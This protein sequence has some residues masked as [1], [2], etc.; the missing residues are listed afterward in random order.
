MSG[1]FQLTLVGCRPTGC[2][3]IARCTVEA[4]ETVTFAVADGTGY[5]IGSPSNATATILNDDV[6]SASIAVSSA[7][8]TADGATKLIYTVTL[9]QTPV[10]PVSVAFTV[11]GTATSGSHYAAVSLPLVIAAG[12][13]SCPVTINPTADATV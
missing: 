8:V 9:S 6:P 11:G 12:E 10:S 4:D 2:Q 3:R 5:S 7:S 13:R 1:G